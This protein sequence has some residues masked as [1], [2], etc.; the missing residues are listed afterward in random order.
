MKKL[1]FLSGLI[2]CFF[3]SSAQIDNNLINKSIDNLNCSIVTYSL[4]SNNDKFTLFSKNCDCSS[5]P[6][7]KIIFK[8]IPVSESK[9]I[10]LSNAI[11]KL[12]SRTDLT[13]LD[14]DQLVNE[15]AEKIFDDKSNLILYEFKKNHKND[16]EYKE[17]LL[18]ISTDIKKIFQEKSLKSNSIDSNAN[19]P[20]NNIQEP[21]PVEEPKSFFKGFVFEIDII[22]ISFTILLFVL[23][24]LILKNN[25]KS[26]IPNN[27]S[28]INNKLNNDVLG[29]TE[30]IR[31]LLRE[32]QI[33]QNKVKELEYKN[34]P[35]NVI[36]NN[37]KEVVYNNQPLTNN[38]SKSNIFYLSNPNSDGSFNDSSS[39]IT[40][41][42][43]ASIYKFTRTSPNTA[44]F[45]IDDRESSIKLALQ[46]PDQAIEPVCDNLNA[47]N[48]KSRKIITDTPGTAQLS[49]GKWKRIKKAQI[50]YES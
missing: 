14:V 40:Y 10:K 38:D 1:F 6:D 30:Q 9:T 17:L 4:K 46:Y 44:T 50:I 48:P 15:L 45:E 28:Q 47:F 24:F 23:L 16:D 2:I 33:L 31:I 49:N 39:S 36:V 37:P 34:I 3:I 21:I 11:E 7:F 22:S 29:H 41:K 5:F 25:S 42:E 35:M 18:K 32:T 19:Q 12:K 43:S 26:N 27:K 8:S 20:E 13:T